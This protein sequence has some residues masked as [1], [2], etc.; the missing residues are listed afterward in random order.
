M[1][2]PDSPTLPMPRSLPVLPLQG[3]TILLV[4][5]SRYAAEAMR[6]LAQRSGARLRRADS[7]QV[8]R[9]HLA[10]YR[11]EAVLVDMGLPDG[12]GAELI[13]EL[14]RDPTAGPVVIALS[15]DPAQRGTALAAGARD[16]LCKPLPG[17]AGFQAVIQRHL[18]D[19]AA[20]AAPPPGDNGLTPDTLALHED[21]RHAADLLERQPD[22][23]GRAYL[24][25]FLTGLGRSIGDQALVRAA[26]GLASKDSDHLPDLAGLV[27]RRIAQVPPP[28]T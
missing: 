14:S 2:L 21:L 23:A 18:P 9:R 27:A 5:D 4:E 13:A 25:R 3:V 15:G 16:F 19:R 10:T 22:A 28:F 7:L 11:P 1:P 26:D 6:L 8:A 20:L 12:P 24:A 17:L